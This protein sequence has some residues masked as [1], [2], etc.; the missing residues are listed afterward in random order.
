MRFKSI[1]KLAGVAFSFVMC[2]SFLFI[3]GSANTVSAGAAKL[4]PHPSVNT[5]S[6]GMFEDWTTMD[7]IE[8]NRPFPLEIDSFAYDSLTSPSKTYTSATQIPYLASSWTASSTQVT[9]KL[10][11]GVTCWNG[12]VLTPAD[13]QASF[14]EY[15]STSKTNAQLFQEFGAGPYTVTSSNAADTFT[16]STKTPYRLLLQEVGS[17]PVVCPQ[18]LAK[19]KTSATALDSATYGTGPYKVISSQHNDD[20]VLQKR[21][22]WNWGPKGGDTDAQL[23][24]TVILKVV[25]DTTTAANL[26]LTGGLDIDE[27]SGSSAYRLLGSHKEVYVRAK[28]WMHL[29]LNFNLNSTSAFQDSVLRQ[30]VLAAVNPKQMLQ[31]AYQGR[32]DVDETTIPN[33]N[34]CYSAAQNSLRKTPSI[35]SAEAILTAGG[36]TDSGGV[37]MKNGQQVTANLLAPEDVGS[38]PDL[39]EAVLT[40]LGFK[41]TLNEVGGSAYGTDFLATDFDIAI[42]RGGQEP[43]DGAIGPFSGPGLPTGANLFGYNDPAL[44]TL[45]VAAAGTAGSAACKMYQQINADEMAQAFVVPVASP[46]AEWFGSKKV[47]TS[48]VAGGA[49]QIPF[50]FIKVK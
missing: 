1:H 48:F 18:G 21:A 37:L 7:P 45:G 22:G 10:K 2:A 24:D 25:P 19:F 4:P 26:L 17:V 8:D 20:V 12:Q 39:L 31:A 38:M 14:Q 43:L 5:L 16:F 11:K 49:S 32:G 29:G 50:Y 35:S 41:V 36:Y 42:E 30:A 44:T 6:I 27:V 23:P 40:E 15:L 33:S 34:E 3:G 46:W 47:L 28:G 9:F 13:V